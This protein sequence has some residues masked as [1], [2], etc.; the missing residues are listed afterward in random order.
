M[1]MAELPP[2]SPLPQLPPDAA[3]AQATKLAHIQVISERLGLG[4]D[5]LGA[6]GGH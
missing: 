6:Y 2:L 5:E 1:R 4:P 3:I